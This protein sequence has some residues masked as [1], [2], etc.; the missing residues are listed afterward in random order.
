MNES[1]DTR[2]KRLIYRSKYRGNKEMDIILGGFA[3]RHVDG[4]SDAE[5]D[6]YE[7]ILFCPDQDLWISGRGSPPADKAGPVMDLLLRFHLEAS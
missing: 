5:L 2:R 3:E 4:F 6:E 7:A 1:P